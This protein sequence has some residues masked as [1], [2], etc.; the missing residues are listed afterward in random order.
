MT[1]GP[2]GNYG[3]FAVK[4]FAEV[5]ENQVPRNPDGHWQWHSPIGSLRRKL[6]KGDDPSNANWQPTTNTVKPQ[7]GW[8]WVAIAH[9]EPQ[10]DYTSSWIVFVARMED[11]KND[12]LL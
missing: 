2:K 7:D 3:P 10:N 11:Y 8:I 12:K 5:V 6:G 4:L 9:Y 1:N